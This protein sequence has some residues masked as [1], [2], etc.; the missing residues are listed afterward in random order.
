MSASPELDELRRSLQAEGLR[1]EDLADEPFTQFGRWFDLAA[2]AGL[3]E[4]E[5]MVVSSVGPD[6][7]PSSRYVLLKGLDHGFVFFTNQR[8][9]KGRELDAHPSAAI[10]FP[11]H[12]LS[13]QFRVKG[14]VE[15]VGD[16]GDDAYFAT[17][18]RGSQIA[19]WASPQ[20]DVLDD[21]AELEARVAEVEARYAGDVPRPP[22]WGGYR[23][24][25]SEVE[26]W[27]GRPDR[28]HDRFRYSRDPD[29]PSG[30]R[31]DRLAP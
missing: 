16:E 25:P 11:W 8:S 17:R 13:R 20:S 14:A 26:V 24:V 5:A 15:R 21:R 6:G 22:H 18:P 31:L 30:W 9:E 10:V 3:H 27:Q 4:P 29:A 23:V 2:G 28:L 7:V 19:A 1:R 12:L